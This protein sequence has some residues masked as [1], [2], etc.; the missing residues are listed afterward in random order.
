MSARA[1][2]PLL[3]LL[4][5]ISAAVSAC[6]GG[7]AQGPQGGPPPAG[8]KIVTL[9]Q[10]PIEQAS[11][12]IATIESRRSTT[13]QPEVDGIITR[14]FVKSGQRVNAGT[15]LVQIN[16]DKQQAAVRSAE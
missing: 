13:V 15:P 8:V 11:E 14:I 10:R 16:A 6:G 12:Y 9:E 5:A 7:S 2:R 3:F 4:A 1:P